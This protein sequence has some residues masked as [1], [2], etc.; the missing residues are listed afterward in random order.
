[1]DLPFQFLSNVAIIHF[2]CLCNPAGRAQRAVSLRSER[3]MSRGFPSL[4]LDT[5]LE[6]RSDPEQTQVRKASHYSDDNKESIIQSSSTSHHLISRSWCSSSCIPLVLPFVRVRVCVS[7]QPPTTSSLS[8]VN[9]YRTDRFNDTRFPTAAQ[10]WWAGW[11]RKWQLAENGHFAD[12][13]LRPLILLLFDDG[14]E[15]HEKLAQ[16]HQFSRCHSQ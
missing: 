16:A 8:S 2:H 3:S 4:E 13:G 6:E 14:A 15:T 12:I 7:P 9:Y 1:M 5:V 10:R 11:F